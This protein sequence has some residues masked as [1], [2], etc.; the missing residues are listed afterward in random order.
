MKIEDKIVEDQKWAVINHKGPI[1]DIEVLIAQLFGWVES[2]NVELVGAPFAMYYTRP[3]NS[4]EDD[5]VYDVGVPIASDYPGTDLIK[6][7][8]ML[9]H[10]VLAIIHKGSY[11]TIN[12]SYQKIVDYSIEN[13]YDIIGSPREIYFNS[14]LDVSEDELITEI[15]LPIIKM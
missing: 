13:K 12:E 5:V 8:D 9:E 15:Q 1:G 10:K 14:P 11:D 7:V 2:E 6:I 3:T 4:K